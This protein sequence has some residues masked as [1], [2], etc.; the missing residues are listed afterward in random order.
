VV[1]PAPDDVWHSDLCW[2]HQ[3]CHQHRPTPVDRTAGSVRVPAGMRVIVRKER[4]HPG[5]QLRFTDTDGLRLTAIITNTRDR[6]LADL[7]LR[8]RRRP[9]RG[10]HPHLQRHRADQPATAR[11]RPEPALVGRGVPRR[12]AHR[13][14]ADAGLHRPPRPAVEP[15]RLRLRLFTIA[16]RLVRHARRRRLR[17]RLSAH[18]PWRHLIETALTRLKALPAPS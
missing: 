10:P 14:V 8:H 3:L 1:S 2:W 18:A 5:A 4:P 16:G 7:E 9:L 6:Q 12:R 15:K 11:V 13:V 17:L